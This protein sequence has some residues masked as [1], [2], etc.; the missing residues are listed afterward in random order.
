M[1]YEE[2][3]IA[4]ATGMQSAAIAVLRISGEKAFEITEKCFKPKNKKRK[5][6]E[7]SHALIF[8]DMVDNN[9]NW[10]DEVLVSVFKNPNSYTGEDTVEISCHGSSFIIQQ[11]IDLYLKN[12]ARMANAGEFTLRAFKNGKLDLAQAEAVADLI[13]SDTQAAHDLAMNQMRGGVSTK[14]KELRKQLIHFAA[15]LELELDFTEEDVE[16]ADRE[17]FLLLVKNL[18]TH[19]Q[20]LINSFQYGN[21]IKDGI[22]IA[23]L[24]KPNAGK[25]SLLNSILNEDKAIVSDIEGTTRDSIEDVVIANGIKFRL[26]DT[27]G[28]RE[29][30][31]TIEALGV[32]RAIANAKKSKLVLFL[33]DTENTQP[34]EI[35][36]LLQPIKNLG[37]HLFLIENKIDVRNG[38]NPEFFNSDEISSLKENFSSVK[39]LGISA[40][41]S[42]QVSDLMTEIAS[43]VK[44]WKNTSDTIITHARHKEALEKTLTSLQATQQ[45]LEMN[46]P[47]DLMAQDVRE[48]IRHLGSI[49]GDIEVDRDILGTIFSEFCIGK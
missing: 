47:G 46:I 42:A 17:E 45:A 16:F 8:G 11:I 7:K 31:D 35:T 9:G 10:I 44:D 28:I 18:Q 30:E 27:A 15:M 19:I 49:T 37:I 34:E 6:S 23:I 21:A 26:I 14:L 39:N 20:T 12:G 32:E 1:N 40:K 2:T 36:K 4:P 48:A 43:L 3:I 33:Y 5:I 41:N 13:A 25:S 24:G 22:P 29:T 38:F